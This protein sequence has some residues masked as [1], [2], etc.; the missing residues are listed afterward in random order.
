MLNLLIDNLSRLENLSSY[1]PSIIQLLIFVLWIFIIRV[2][3]AK[4][5]TSVGWSL[6][7]LL[8]SI[9]AQLFTLT[10]LA[11]MVAEYSFMF[12]GIGIIQLTVFSDS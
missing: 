1:I 8:V 2:S 4:Y 5:Q 6:F 3:K 9:V 11:Q 7:L 12:L 10:F